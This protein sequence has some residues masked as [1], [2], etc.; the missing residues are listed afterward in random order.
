MTA[1]KEAAVAALATTVVK[2]VIGSKTALIL[3]RLC[4]V[5]VM[6]RV[7]RAESA[8]FPETIPA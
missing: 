5:T 2:K 1:H 7:T 3:A 4:A 8:R 6:R